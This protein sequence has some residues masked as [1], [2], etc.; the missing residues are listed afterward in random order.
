MMR[1]GGGGKGGGVC[2]CVFYVISWEYMKDEIIKDKTI[3][4]SAGESDGIG[5][6]S[7]Y[8]RC[9]KCRGG[10]APY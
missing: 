10:T 1:G 5:E 6:D 7:Y 9:V 2:M 3:D 8:G 4:A